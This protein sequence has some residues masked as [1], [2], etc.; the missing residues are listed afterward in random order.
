LSEQTMRQRVIGIL[1]ELDAFS[2]ENIVRPGTPDINFIPGWLELKWLREWPGNADKSP[3]LIPHF[4][5]QQRSFLR[6]RSR[7]EGSCWVLLQ[8]GREWILLD[9]WIAAKW[10]GKAT[11]K[12]LIRMSTKYWGQGLKDKELLACLKQST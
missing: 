12:E 3:V 4:T 9:G 11:R 2:V 7:A 1:K 8:V 5:L 10:L 6:Q